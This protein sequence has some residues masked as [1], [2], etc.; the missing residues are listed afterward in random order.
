MKYNNLLKKKNVADEKFPN[1]KNLKIPEI[2][3]YFSTDFIVSS[4]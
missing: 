1:R 2:V 4:F 3:R